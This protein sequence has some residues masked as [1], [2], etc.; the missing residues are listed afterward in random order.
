[1]VVAVED[2]APAMDL[3]SHTMQEVGQGV[4]LG[5]DGNLGTGSVEG[6]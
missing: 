2:E 3:A 4:E 5:K 6:M 1:V